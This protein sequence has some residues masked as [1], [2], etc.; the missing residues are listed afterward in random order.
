MV[1]NTKLY[2]VLEVN[3]QCNDNELKK[4]YRAKSMK[5]HPD[6]NQTNKDEATA[7]FQEISEA[8]SILSDK[9]KRKLYDTIGLDILKNGS[10]GPPVDPS[11]IFEQF[12]GNMGGFGSFG[13]F[14]GFPFGNRR[15]PQEKIDHCEIDKYVTLEEIYNSKTVRVE[16]KQKNYCKT[17]DGIGTK[18]KKSS[19]CTSCNGQGKVMEMRQL[20]PGMIQQVVVEC[21]DCRGTGQLLDKNNICLDCNGD[22]FHFKQ[23]NISIPLK[24]ELS[25]GNQIK[26]NN[27]GHNLKSGKTSLIITIKL[28][29]HNL[30]KK[31]END[32]HMELEIPL[33][34]DLF[35]FSKVITHLDN[36]KLLVTND[37]VLDK[38]GILL[39]RNEG[40]YS[41]N[42]EKGHLFIHFKTKFPKLSKLEDNEIDVLKKLLIKC[43]YEYYK[44][45]GKIDKTDCINLNCTKIDPEKFNYSYAEQHHAS[46]QHASQQHASQ[47][48]ASQQHASQ[49]HASQQ[50][51]SQQ[52]ASQQ[53]GEDDVRGCAQQ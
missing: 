26:L 31:I 3:P 46:Q 47:H 20:G 39:V 49:Q 48:H 21:K 29:P 8:Y 27:K 28:N 38:E 42:G 16:Y 41:P 1:K 7:K 50:H 18:N 34:Q 23:K 19:K 45:E 51:A 14:G 17:C 43:D 36:R 35:D 32:L 52:H 2:D 11:K 24:R 5:W 6:K 9:E 33:Y 25:D 37:N 4:A 44:E 30:F 40:L 22:K 13:G 12:F 53:L 15:Q 10:D